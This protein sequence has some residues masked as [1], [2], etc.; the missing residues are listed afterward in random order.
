V[1]GVLKLSPAGRIQRVEAH[2]QLINAQIGG[3]FPFSV[4]RGAVDG[5]MLLDPAGTSVEGTVQAQGLQSGSLSLARLAANVSLRGGRGSIR[6]SMAGSRG[7]SFEFQTVATVAPGQ[8]QIIGQGSV[9]RRPIKLTTPAVLVAEGNGWRLQQ[10][11]LTFAGGSARVSGQ[12]GTDST[13][14]DA[15]IDAMPLTIFDIVSPQLGLGGLASGTLHYRHASGD[16]LPKGRADLRVRG[17]TRSGLVLSSQPLDVGIAAVLDGPSAGM[18]AVA[19]SNGHE[20]GRLQARITGMGEGADLATRITH[21]PLF[22]QLRYNGPAD[23]LWRLTGIETFDLSGP[24][25]IGADI[26][27][28]LAAP[29]ILGSVKT[30]NARLES[31]VSGMILTGV[32]ERWQGWERN[33]E[34]QFQLRGWPWHWH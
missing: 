18:R 3:S 11:S 28:S 9:D 17:M 33:R 7:R 1:T 8:W 29:Q 4:R 20:V 30:E 10:S 31:A 6:A 13:D 24:A 22:A 16:A 21:A 19:A 32:G 23:T 2:L 12:F 25:N 14:V 27:G 34:G 15:T 5:V 26:S